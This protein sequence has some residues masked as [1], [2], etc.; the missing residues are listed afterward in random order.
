M[1]FVSS[2]AL[3]QLLVGFVETL[4]FWVTLHDATGGFLAS[5][6]YVAGVRGELANGGG[7]FRDGAAAACHFQLADQGSGNLDAADVVLNASGE[8]IGPAEHYAVWVNAVNDITANGGALLIGVK[9][10]G[11]NPQT[12]SDGNPMTIPISNIINIPIPI[13]A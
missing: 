2:T 1:N 9:D 3:R 5:D 11:G 6:Q 12:A 10:T 13:A 8:D 7:Y 4:H